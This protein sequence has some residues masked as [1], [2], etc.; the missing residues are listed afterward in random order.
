MH[1]RLLFFSE[2]TSSDC[3]LWFQLWWIDYLG[4]TKWEKKSMLH[5]FVQLCLCH[6]NNT[7]FSAMVTGLTISSLGY[8]KLCEI[9][10]GLDLTSAH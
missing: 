6:P 4:S 9:E 2:M 5:K 10:L 1:V 7:S 8:I 3:S